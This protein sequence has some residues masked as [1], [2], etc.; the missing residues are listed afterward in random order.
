M[1]SADQLYQQARQAE[2]AGQRQQALALYLQLQA[3]QPAYPN[4]NLRLGLLAHQAGQLAEAEGYYLAELALR[5]DFW[6]C[7]AN[8]AQV[9]AEQ[10]AWPKAQQ[11]LELALQHCPAEQLPELTLQSARCLRAQQAYP[12][13]IA[14][15][16][17]Q[18][19][20]G[21]ALAPELK[22]RLQ[23]ELARNY[24]HLNEIEAAREQLD[25][26]AALGERSALLEAADLL[27]ST[28]SFAAASLQF[29]RALPGAASAR[30]QAWLLGQMANCQQELNQPE[31][32]LTLYEQ[33]LALAPLPSLQMA[34]AFV[35]PVVYPSHEQL[36]HW[37]QHFQQALQALT[38]QSLDTSNPLGLTALPFYLPYQG[39]NERAHLSQLGQ[40]LAGQLPPL[41]SGLPAGR[42]T[43][44]RGR[45]VRVGCV[46]RFFYQHSVIAPFVG[47][48]QALGQA[49]F[50]WHAL[51]LN[52]LLED[53]LTWELRRS[54]RSWQVLQGPLH[55]QLE[56]VQRL[57]LDILLYT[58]TCLD[59]HSYLLS[60]YRLAPVQV[61]LPGQPL[62]S[63]VPQLDKV[64]SDS[65]SEPAGAQQHYSE[66]LC[67]MPQIPSLAT[68]PTVPEGPLPSREQL[69]L[70]T[71]HLYLCPA[72]VFKLVPQMDP[73]FA[74][75]LQADPQA[76]LLFL[77]FS[78]RGLEQ[79]FLSRLKA[80]LEP[81][82]AERVLLLPRFSQLRFL[83]V[84][85]RVE[86]LLESFPFGSW[87]TLLA[88]LAVNT[89][90][91]SLESEFLRGR[92]ALGLLRQMGLSDNIAPT[93]EAYIQLAVS[94]AQNPQ[95]RARRSQ[96]LQSHKQRVLGVAAALE[97][98][99]AQLLSWAGRG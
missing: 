78:G 68:P 48:L 83:Q 2:A 13:A 18:L 11:Q 95:L 26:A 32:A 80:R 41:V 42:P 98:V 69:G 82:Q 8:L 3:Q 81:G 88:A 58:D 79:Q 33:A 9:L 50:E 96:A 71:G 35:L 66:Q 29:Q 22:A 64:L 27:V 84:L 74:G 61:L 55:K 54:A 76:R 63:G 47:L 28:Q 38:R 37:R 16:K 67:L 14:A 57:E 91:V 85:Q 12:E 62:T 21:L 92:Y 93:P 86:V 56:S 43:A 60:H 5:P 34:R 72:Q 53:S 10:E 4:L 6:G 44:H 25:Q 30:E 23:R 24:R 7:R 45:S 36:L 17:T 39:F 49:P 52:P 97:P 51:S 70:P 94:L 89:P 59:P 20:A 73:V 46:S 15:L 90:F 31:Q 65:Y 99:K 1:V 75:I 87:N 40:W 77:D 19:A